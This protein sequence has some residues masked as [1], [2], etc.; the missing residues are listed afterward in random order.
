VAVVR[1]QGAIMARPGGLAAGLNLAGIA[2]VLERAFALK[3]ARAVFLVINSPGGSAVQSS[4][5]AARIRALAE[6]KKLP[7]VA[8]VEDAAASGGYWLACAADEIVADPG[9][10]LGSI[11]VIAQGFGFPEALAKLGV[12]RRLRTAGEEKSFWDP[13][14]PERPED[15]ARLDTLLA[16]LHA[17]FRAWVLARRGDRLRAPAEELFTG[18]F[19]GGRRA[20]ELG[21][22][23]GLGDL[24]GEARRRYG[25]KVR[26]VWFG[27]RRRGL[28]A[29][30]LPGLSMQA[31]LAGL[32]E[33]ALWQRLGL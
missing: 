2:P 24:H 31:L 8:C 29:R 14:R 3:R 21:L 25:E 23:D 19:W 18:R 13:F 5:I 32:E 10:I 26:L 17:E 33:R 16:E 6:E 20:V 9:S 7:V 15:L 27:G 30:L 4:L 1:L 28:L 12:E 22:A 11:G